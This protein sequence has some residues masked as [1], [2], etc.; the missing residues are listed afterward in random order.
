M[1]APARCVV[2]SPPHGVYELIWAR[3]FVMEQAI[4][5]FFT[6]HVSRFTQA[7]EDFD[8][9]IDRQAEADSDAIVA[10]L[11]RSIN[12]SL[13]DCTA[14]EAQL[15][16]SDPK[17]LK[18]AQS[19][20]REAIWPWFGLSWFMNHAL[21]K[22]RGYPGDYHM[23]TSIYEARPK[24]RGLG[25]YL[26]RYFLNTQLGRAVVGRLRLAREFLLAEVARHD[27]DFA[28]LNVAC[29]PCREYLGGLG[30]AEHGQTTIT[31]VDNDPLALDYVQANVAPGL[32][33]S[34]KLN[35]V[36]YNALRMTSAV[37][38]V[39]R[40]GRSDLIYSVG[41]CDYI[42]DKFLIP[43]LQGWRGS[44]SPGGTVYV[45]FKDSRRYTTPEYQWLVDWFFL[46]RTEE[47]CRNLFVAAGYDMN[48]LEMVRDETGII[49]N[50]IAR[51]K[52]PAFVRVDVPAALPLPQHGNVPAH[53]EEPHGS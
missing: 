48:E 47:E 39:E 29:G 15:A 38:N 42:P 43:M 22:P 10:E 12:A 30:T 26:D 46:Q 28:V 13:A 3:D 41:L 50:F 17:I 19:R 45:A 53:S 37:V 21:S 49:I 2:T 5:R 33:G 31:L 16:G 44:L 25:G 34:A 1:S 23:L 36:R 51:S 27:G 8:R 40:F 14:L 6:E 7:L 4:S 32:I 35:F 20:Y 52:V 9:H 11:T 24:S 18:D